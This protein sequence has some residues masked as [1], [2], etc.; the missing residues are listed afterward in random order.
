MAIS[1]REATSVISEFVR[2]GYYV[3]DYDSSKEK[4]VFN[5]TVSLKSSFGK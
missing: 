3:T 4:L 5:Q 1:I 2:C